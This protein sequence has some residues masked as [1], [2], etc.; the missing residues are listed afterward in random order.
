LRSASARSDVLA[1]AAAFLRDL[2]AAW[3]AAT[4]EQ[5]NDLARLVFESVEV[6][7]G[8]VIAVVVN[9]DFAPFFGVFGQQETPTGGTGCQPDGETLGP[10]EATG[11]EPALSALTALHV[12][13][14]KVVLA[15][16]A[17]PFVSFE[18]D[19]SVPS[20]PSP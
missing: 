13:P 7:D 15:T 20:R 2:P 16:C 19:C 12:K 17:F 11:F 10:A 8:Q 3:K 14:A 1:Q 9:P 5:R 18:A 4:P 6:R